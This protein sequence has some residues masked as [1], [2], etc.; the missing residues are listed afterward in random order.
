MDNRD[1]AAAMMRLMQAGYFIRFEQQPNGGI[2]AL[3]NI[4]GEDRA[5]GFGATYL[6]ALQNMF[7]D[8]AYMRL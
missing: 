2:W 3:A 8:F 5:C 6:A 4:S 1:L 7:V